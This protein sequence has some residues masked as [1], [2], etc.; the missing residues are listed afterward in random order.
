VEELVNVASF[1]KDQKMNKFFWFA[2]IIMFL[3][4]ISLPMF[5]LEKFFILNDSFSL[6]GGVFQLAVQGEW[7]LA[8]VIFCF[9]I[10]VPLYKFVLFF[11][12]H[13]VLLS[14]VEKLLLIKHLMLIGKW[15]MADVFL[16]AVLAATVKLG[17]L[18]SVKAHIGLLFFGGSVL[19]SMVLSH[20]VLAGYEIKLI[21]S[22]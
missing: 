16:I 2:S 4:G 1:F 15:S 19:L 22:Q 3:L 13:S 7:L 8:S 21:E 9:S 17:G 14:S 5:S 18:A 11:R 6:L 20:R 12:I 10:L